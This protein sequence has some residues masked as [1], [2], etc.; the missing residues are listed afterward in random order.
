MGAGHLDL[1]Y[2]LAWF[3][4]WMWAV[5]ELIGG[6][7]GAWR[8]MPL[9]K[10]LLVG[11]FGGL[12]LL[13]DVRL[14]LFAYLL[15][16]AYGLYEAIRQSQTR[17]LLWFVPAGIVVLLLTIA[18]IAPLLAWRPYLSRAGMTPAD[19]GVFSLEPAQLI[20]LLLPARGGNIETLT[21]LGLPVLA[22]AIVG[23]IT[24]RR[25]FWIGAA[26]VAAWWALGQNGLL[27]STLVQIV[28]ALLWFRVPSRA[29][30]VVALI[31]P[32]LAGYG[33]E[34]LLDQRRRGLLAALI[35]T[36][37]AVVG[38]LFFAVSVPA[39]N[40][41]ALLIGGGGIGLITLL[42]FSGQLR[43]N[44]LAAAVLVVTFLD[45]AISGRGWLEWRTMEAWLPP[46]QV[47]LAERLT[48]LGAY[49]VYSPTYSLQQPAAEDYHLRLF[50]GVDPFQLKGVVEAVEQGGGIK[51]TGYSVVMPPLD[52]A[53]LA[54]ANRE[55]VPDTAALGRWGVT[56]VVSAYPLD[57]PTLEQVDVIGGVYVY[58]NHDPTLT[59]DFGNP[60]WPK[61]APD[62]PDPATVQRLNQLTEIAALISGAALLVVLALLLKVRR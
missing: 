51:N 6:G 54:Q 59:T 43:G 8:A 58:A 33:L 16:G 21:Y 42:A 11:L 36:V 26:G 27:W 50:G 14:S 28:P 17:R 4:W 32:L 61:D 47:L 40:G 52:S 49:R 19:A 30:F 13:A 12:M 20:G 31:A 5:G 45:L 56:H 25:W 18:V 46:N 10:I 57:V 23:A 55:A 62:L 37:M 24:A 34:W 60:A 48:E 1:L 9:R 15:A 41:L 38:G 44:R 29:W 22:L 53:D 7:V 2:A 39:I 3:P 35:G